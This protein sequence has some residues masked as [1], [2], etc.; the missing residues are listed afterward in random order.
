MGLPLGVIVVVGGA[1]VHTVS[2]VNTVDTLSVARHEHRRVLFHVGVVA[3][4]NLELVVGV[5]WR[6]SDD[7][8]LLALVDHTSDDDNDNCV[9]KQ[10]L[11][12]TGTATAAAMMTRPPPLPPSL[13]SVVVTPLLV[14]LT[15][16][17][18]CPPMV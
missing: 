1:H 17:T 10:V 18:A 13:E 14:V 7:C 6:V 2:R 4:D 9:T 15:D 5:S 16:S 8:V 12:T 3:Y 11:M